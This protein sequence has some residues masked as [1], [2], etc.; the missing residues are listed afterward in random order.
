MSAD[1]RKMVL[2]TA[3]PAL[4]PALPQFLFQSKNGD[5]RGAGGGKGE[6]DELK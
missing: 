3:V 2:Q 4:S 1:T 6:Q 5:V